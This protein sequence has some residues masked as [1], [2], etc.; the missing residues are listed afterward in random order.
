[1]GSRVNDVSRAIYRLLSEHNYGVVRPYC[2][3]GVGL[4]LHEDPQIP[5]YVGRGPNPRLKA[6]MVI[7]IEPMVNLGGDGVDVL[8]DDWTVVT[9]DRSVSAHFEHTVAIFRDH[10][11]VLTRRRSEAIH[12]TQEASVS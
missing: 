5:N 9:E 6:G 1:V 10:T 3:H 8:E 12:S 11:E 2:G 4:E 7:A